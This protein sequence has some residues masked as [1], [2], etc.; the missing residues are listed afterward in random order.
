MS[1]TARIILLRGAMLIACLTMAPVGTGAQPPTDPSL[2]S[3]D[4]FVSDDGAFLY[5]AVCQ[6]C[7]MQD[8]GG[9]KG[10]GSY[11][12]LASDPRL[13]SALYPVVLVANG[14]KAMPPL[15]RWLDDAQ[16]AAVVNYVRSHF[17]NHY[18]DELSAQQVK[19]VR[20]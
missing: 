14:S 10:A 20:Q 17:G 16:I 8:G 12:S 3:P 7:H 4:H 18:S 5:R 13:A 1:T 9:A 19:A 11:P 15:G 6:G 2:G